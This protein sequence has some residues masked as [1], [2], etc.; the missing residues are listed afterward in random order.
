MDPPFFHPNPHESP[1]PQR[2]I[3]C[4]ELYQFLGALDEKP[5]KANLFDHRWPSGSSIYSTEGKLKLFY[6]PPYSPELNLDEQG[7]NQLKKH[8]IG[9]MILKSL[10]DMTEKVHSSMR[11]IQRSPALIQSFFLHKDCCYAA[12]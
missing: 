11:S 1:K 9:K 3:D 8:R 10:E 6:L 5:K 12:I 7:W 4:R 2:K